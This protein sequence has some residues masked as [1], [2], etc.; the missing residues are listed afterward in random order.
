MNNQ[1]DKN[2]LGTYNY[3]I[4]ASTN[5]LST[6]V[7]SGPDA[8]EVTQEVQIQWTVKCDFIVVPQTTP[9]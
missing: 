8:P 6:A 5:P 9:D 3:W 1:V 2:T 7:T 4:K